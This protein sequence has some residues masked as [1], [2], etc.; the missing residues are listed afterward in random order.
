M[1]EEVIRLARMVREPGGR[2][3]LMREYIQTFVLRSLHEAEAFHSISF[4]GGTALRFLHG[5]PRFSEDLDFSLETPVGYKPKIW[6]DK[7]KRD[8]KFAGFEATVTW[9]DR[10]PVNI[11]WIR[12]S[13]ILHEVGLAPIQQQKIAVKLEIDSN[14][15]AGA[16]TRTTVV[17]RHLMFA[18]R[19]HNLQSLMAGKVHALWTRPFLKGRDWYDLIWYCSKEPRIEPNMELLRN[20]LAQTVPALVSE[21]STWRRA[22]AIKIKKVGFEGLRE[23]VEPFLERPQDAAIMSSDIIVGLLASGE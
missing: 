1:R 19:H 7:L 4:V 14:P 21:A 16:V 18:L 2:L 13:Q 9:N 23:D 11:A 10:R 6:L 8:L 15:P 12:I 17:Q 22:L 20:A 3:N 5:L